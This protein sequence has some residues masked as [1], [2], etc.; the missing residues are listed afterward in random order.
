MGRNIFLF[1]I[2]SV[3]LCA[4]IVLVFFSADITEYAQGGI[5]GVPE[6]EVVSEDPAQMLFVG[7]IMLARHVERLMGQHGVGYPFE[8]VHE[9]FTRYDAIVG[10]FEATIPETHIHTPD[11]TFQF[12]VRPTYLSV[13][14]DV[15]FTHLSLANNHAY[16]F[17][18]AGYI[19]TQKVCAEHE[20][21]C[22]G[23]PAEVSGV[24]VQHLALG[25][26]SIAVIAIHDT[27]AYVDRAE[28]DAVLAAHSKT[29]V[30]YLFAYIHWGEEY[31]KLHSVRQ[32]ALAHYLIE[33]G[34]DAVIG[35]HPH[36]VQDIEIYEGRPIFYSLGN[37]IFDQY[38]VD[39]VQYGLG[40]EV[41]ETSEGVMFDLVPFTSIDTRSQP[42]V[43]PE[44][45]AEHF[46][47][48]IPGAAEI[49][50]YTMQK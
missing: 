5:R 36:V 12:S 39:E 48:T 29:D 1:L 3:A 21:A 35:H 37:F 13:L 28:I 30:S 41:S 42:H 40:V 50:G 38:F 14:K 15:G 7:D 43:M 16:D 18:Q 27:G 49:Q 44:T 47:D 31:E 17:G 20:L 19:H 10:N 9:A 33:N 32:E 45:E 26:T 11:F 6:D 23:R 4:S 24:S 46:L 22:F 2:L 34:V 8:G 25:D